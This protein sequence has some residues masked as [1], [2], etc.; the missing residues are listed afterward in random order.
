MAESTKNMTVGAGSA[1]ASVTATVTDQMP[2][3]PC[4]T[5]PGYEYTGM[6]YVPVF[7]DPPEWSSA[8]SYEALEIVIHEGNSYTSKTFV[9]VGI[10]ISNSTYWVLTGNYN[11]QVEQ[12]RQEVALLGKN[13][14]ANT[15]DIAYIKKGY[16]KAYGTVAEMVADSAHLADGNTALVLGYWN[17]GDRGGAEYRIY[18][19]D[20][21]GYSVKVGNMFAVPIIGDRIPV[22]CFGAKGDGVTDDTA[23][24][25][26]AIDYAALRYIGY[27]MQPSWVYTYNGVDVDMG[28]KRYKAAS[29]TVKPGVNLVGDGMAILECSSV[30]LVNA[31]LQKLVRGIAFVSMAAGLIAQKEVDGSLLR[32]EKCN[33]YGCTTA[34]DASG[35]RSYVMKVVD[36][37]FYGCETVLTTDCDMA[38]FEKCFVEMTGYTGAPIVNTGSSLNVSN[39][40][41]VPTKETTRWIDAMNSPSK[42]QCVCCTETRF[43][44][45]GGGA[46]AIIY[47]RMEAKQDPTSVVK[48][49]II[50]KNCQTTCRGD[51]VV[52]LFGIPNELTIEDCYGFLNLVKG[53]VVADPALTVFPSPQFIRFNIDPN[54]YTSFSYPF[55]DAKVVDYLST[56]NT[57]DFSQNSAV[58]AN[59]RVQ[60]AAGAETTFKKFKTRGTNGK[61]FMKMDVYVTGISTGD[62]A[63]YELLLLYVNNV[64]TIVKTTEVYK[65]SGITSVEFSA[66]G[67]EVKINI[68]SNVGSFFVNSR[69]VAESG[70]YY[71]AA[72]GVPFEDGYLPVGA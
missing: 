49:S 30:T 62:A 21:G 3:V 69:S 67:E 52:H 66:T 53:I 10:D 45:E 36:C 16:A 8:N 71:N 9:P 72:G 24:I 38:V 7:A 50:L 5:S 28:S 44:G 40:I 60:I 19:T 51:G 1:S 31:G 20:P 61:L 15:G 18:G 46:L 17:P 12:Y 32:I 14:E 23:A 13:V 57:R 6:R 2:G 64:P 4:P 37:L 58:L 34:I 47:N 56:M 27:Q 48:N 43:G 70:Y 39:C 41:F 59:T 68:T 42:Q 63:C 35:V 11:Y 65:S 22:A 26:S 33:F 25:Q 29:L 55:V 54:S